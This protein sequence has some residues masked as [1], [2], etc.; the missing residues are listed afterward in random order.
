MR[1]AEN[2]KIVP[3]TNDTAYSGG[4]SLDSVNMRNHRHADVVI[5]CKN[6]IGNSALKV[7]SGATAAAK[8]TAMIFDYAIGSGTVGSSS[9]DVL[10]STSTAV[11]ASGMTL[12]A[13]SVSSAMTVLSIDAAQMDT[14]NAHEWMTVEIDSTASSGSCTAVAI[15]DPRYTSDKSATAI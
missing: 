6:A 14:A 15:L 1:L 2:M 9:A 11:A 4:I 12:T 13:S 10:G 5:I 7:Y 3:L 8:T